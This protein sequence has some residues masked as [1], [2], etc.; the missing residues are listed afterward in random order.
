MEQSFS[1]KDKVIVVTGGTGIL[2]NAFVNAIVEAGGAV[3][4]LG[5]NAEIANEQG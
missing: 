4:I 2:G 5:R 3:G 1:L